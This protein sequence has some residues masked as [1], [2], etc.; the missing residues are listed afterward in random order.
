MSR[1]FK[2]AIQQSRTGS[3]Q[4]VLRPT[5]KRRIRPTKRTSAPGRCFLPPANVAMPE[6][7][8]RR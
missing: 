4:R 1:S 8:V 2:V 5:D 7:E 3:A 6:R